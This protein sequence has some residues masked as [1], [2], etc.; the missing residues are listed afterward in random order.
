MKRLLPS[1]GLFV[2]VIVPLVTVKFLFPEQVGLGNKDHDVD[3]QKIVIVP[4]AGVPLAF[5]WSL[6]E[7]LEAQHETDVL[8]TT[9]L[10]KGGE[11]L[12]PGG[13]QLTA[14]YLASV[15]KEIA[16]RI[17][18]EDAFVILLTNEDINYPKSGLRYVYSS[19]YEGVSVVSLA[20]I[21]VMN[22]GVVPNLIEVPG[23]FSIMKKRALKL[24]NKA[25][26]YGYYGYDASSNI[27]SVMY[28]PIMG[29]DDLDRVGS[30]Y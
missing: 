29:P 2:L 25:I 28:G 5:L 24:I 20:R 14:S 6:E 23:M 10:G 21:N 16:E 7:T 12:L 9:A 4:T 8:V 13:D 17:G 1:I 3:G 11:M 15:G 18:R 30:W 26:G 19:H 22:L 27:D